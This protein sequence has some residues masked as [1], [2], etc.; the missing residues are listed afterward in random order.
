MGQF[1]TKDRCRV[2]VF[3]N[4]GDRE[5]AQWEY[6]NTFHFRADSEAIERD[7]LEGLNNLGEE[8]WEVTA[9][10]N[11]DTEQ[12]QEVLILKRPRPE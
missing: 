6:Y 1:A 3:L 7:H 10:I 2:N 12:S 8:G 11:I 5:M 4:M 9:T